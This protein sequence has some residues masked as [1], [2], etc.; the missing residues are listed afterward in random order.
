MLAPAVLLAPLTFKHWPLWPA[1]QTTDVV[2]GSSPEENVH[3]KFELA[4]H[5]D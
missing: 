5:E 4:L 1:C 2:A 3:T